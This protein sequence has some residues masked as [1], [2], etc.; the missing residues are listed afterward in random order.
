MPFLK[1]IKR[2]RNFSIIIIPEETSQKAKTV[3]LSFPN[4]AWIIALYTLLS[5]IIGYYTLS[6]SGLD[7]YLAPVS[8]E[9]K[10]SD[11]LLVR[12][13]NTKIIFLVKELD[14]LKST[15][16]KLKYAL[17]LGDSTL[18]DSS[19]ENSDSDSSSDKIN[20]EGNILKIAEQLVFKLYSQSDIQLF[21]KPVDGFVSKIFNP[22]KGHMGVD[23]VVKEGTPVYAAGGGYIL[24]SDYT[25]DD[26]YMIIIIHRDGYVSIYKHCSSLI[27]GVRENVEQG[28][29]I[30]LSGNSGKQTTGPHLHLEIWRDGKPVNPEKQFINY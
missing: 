17:L 27:K 11:R 3:K 12:D 16:G 30:A 18:F 9:L 15:N 5:V 21:T 13:L 6:I 26:G 25:I 22:E 29:L 10:E 8:A 1:Y 14:K 4:L 23:F 7:Y 28:E 24:F 20:I 19:N 2:I